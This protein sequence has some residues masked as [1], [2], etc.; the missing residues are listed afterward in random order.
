MY[1]VEKFLIMVIKAVVCATYL[2]LSAC[3]KGYGVTTIPTVLPPATK[4]QDSVK[5]QDVILTL[6]NCEEDSLRW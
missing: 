4:G 5:G 1:G 2:I 6:V 3:D